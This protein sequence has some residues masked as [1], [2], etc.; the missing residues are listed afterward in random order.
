[1]RPFMLRDVI[2]DV[3]LG[4]KARLAEH[5][6]RLLIDCPADI[7]IQG[8]PVL[9]EQ[10]LGA[11]LGNALQHG[12]PSAVAGAEIKLWAWISGDGQLHLLCADNGAGMRADVIERIF[13]PFFTTSRG[14]GSAGLGLYLCYNI[15][16]SRL[17]GKIACTSEVGGGAAF[18]ATIPVHNVEAER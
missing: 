3:A 13:E 12:F 8:Q 6:V 7:V 16:T 10:I 15:T 17:G 18:E 14:Q 11:L 1:M 5:G 4:F 9:Y 2:D